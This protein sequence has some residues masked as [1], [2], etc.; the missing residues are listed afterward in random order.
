[1][2]S[3]TLAD[4]PHVF[5]PGSD[6]GSAALVAL[7][8]TGGSETD[9]AAF[10][11]ALDPDAAVLAPRGLVTE[12]PHQRWFRRL[13]E[14]VF[15][16]DDVQDRAHELAAFVTAARDAY[17]LQGRRIIAIGFSNG[18]NMGL[19]LAILHPDLLDG[20]IAFSGMYPFADR[21]I[22]ARLTHFPVLLLNGD[23][24]P[25]APNDSVTRLEER[26]RE[27][28]ANVTRRTRP[29]GH[30]IEPDETDTAREWLHATYDQNHHS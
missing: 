25:M 4:Q 13:S 23:Q 3:S 14:G 24:D 30:G 28:G 15:D 2:P 16:V 21:V 26:L 9:M 20:V 27:G 18:A 6:S 17:D 29:G 11:Q 5:L 7:H 1:M 10:A 12:G 19:A 22:D 8:G